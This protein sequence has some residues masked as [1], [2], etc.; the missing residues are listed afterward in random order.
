VSSS[1]TV[2][3]L[4][5]SDYSE[6]AT[7][8]AESPD[9]SIYANTDY[10]D[11]LCSTAG[12]RFRIV[13]VRR[14]DRIV[15]GIPLYEQES[16]KGVVVSPRGLLYY[17]GPVLK[18]SESKYPSKQTAHTLVM[19]RALVSEL[20]QFRYAK[21]ILRA[22]HTLADVRPFLAEGWSAWPT[23]SYLLSLKDLAGHWNLV[24]HNLRRLID[25][26]TEQ[27]ISH[28]EDDD[29][30]SFLRLHKLTMTHHDAPTYL[31]D[32]AF[33]R[34]FQILRESGRCR[35]FHA[36]L[37]G[38]ESIGAQVVLMGDHPVSHTV[39]AA[40]DPA[41]RQLGSAAFLRW[42]TFEWLARHGKSAND[43]TDADLNSVTHFKSQLGGELVTNLVVA[44]PGTLNWRAR[45]VIEGAYH[46]ARRR[47]GRVVRRLHHRTPA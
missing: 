28:T 16:R 12:G 36:R 41:R 42:R 45:S 32:S 31:P 15:G 8:V 7:L 18:R 34:W 27:N 14:A 1:L 23:Y 20:K 5:E 13:V 30:E 21:V 22:R 26:C 10:L 40:I 17:L 24:E 3:T 4:R 44:T 35:L 39:T 43:L 2:H 37:P 46:G 6:W 25:R 47:A 29:F 9:G 19:L 33:R 38:G 11:A